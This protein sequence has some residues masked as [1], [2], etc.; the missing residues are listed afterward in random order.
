[1]NKC[2]NNAARGSALQLSI[3]VALSCLAAIFFAATFRAAP[4]LQPN[5]QSGSVPRPG[6]NPA[7]PKSFPEFHRHPRSPNTPEQ[8][9][10]V[11]APTFTMD[12][13]DGF[14][15]N[16]QTVS[17]SNVDPALNYTGFQADMILTP[18]LPRLRLGQVIVLWL[19]LDSPAV[20]PVGPLLETLSIADQAHL[21][22][23]ASRP[24]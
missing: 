21:K 17:V 19:Q 4:N 12:V 22:P 16:N 8:A 9:V 2:Q 3:T 11:T 10:A 5:D 18:Q 15:I 20:P 23:C 24:S 14:A 13:A 6:F 1:M 7:L